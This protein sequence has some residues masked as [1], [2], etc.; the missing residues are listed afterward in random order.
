MSQPA[1][2]LM[3]RHGESLANLERRFTRSDDEPLTEL[4]RQQ[5]I[6][7]ARR[8]QPHYQPTAIYCS[9]FHRA[10]TTA[11]L[12]ASAFELEAKVVEG[13]HEQSFGDLRGAPYE[14]LF[15]LMGE[16]PAPE[17]RW[18]FSVPRGETLSQ[19]CERAGAV[20]DSLAERHRGEQI[21]VVSHGGVMAALRAHVA[22][23]FHI[24]PRPTANAWG[25][26]LQAS[27]DPEGG[28]RYDGPFALLGD[29]A[30]EAPG[31]EP[32]SAG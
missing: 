14:A 32:I 12:I 13:I 3:I 28:W 31:V 26:R 11:E 16:L 17:E 10:R 2:L 7:T 5:A 18:F 8:L 24:P 22:G 29:G 25:Y 20:V 1:V 15:D 6:E 23:G 27:A 9:S 21:M 30:E 19:V 4:G